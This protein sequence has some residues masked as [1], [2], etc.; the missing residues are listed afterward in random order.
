M[1]KA[2]SST[3]RTNRARARSRICASDRG[4]FAAPYLIASANFIGCHQFQF[5]ERL[6]LLKL[7]APGAAFLLNCP[8]GAT[9][10]WDHLPRSVQQRIIDQRLRF[11]VIDASRVAQDAGLGTHTNTVLQTCFFAISGVMPREEAIVQIKRSIRT[12]YAAKGEEVVQQNFRVV[13]GALA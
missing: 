11:F 9:E 2:T 5:V 10:V 4:R 12:T 7:A 3:I 6:D 1:R 8:Y 13:E